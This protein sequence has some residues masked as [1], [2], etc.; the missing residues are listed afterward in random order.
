MRLAC[1]YALLDQSA[2]VRRV[3][4]NAALEL[5]RF[6]EDSARFI[7]GDA[8]GNPLADAIVR[9]LRQTSEGM[10]R[11]QI[12]DLFGRN[13]NARE[14]ERALRILA[15]QGVAYPRHKQTEGRPTERWFAAVPATTKTTETTEVSRAEATNC[16]SVV[17]VVDH[18]TRWGGYASD[19]DW[20]D[21]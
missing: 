6:C 15:E 9:A 17:N 1:L 16:S 19:S 7:F 12:R 3:H 11:T 21:V 8:L 2:I 5:W 18:E 20:A 4:L 10:T 13:R 14:I